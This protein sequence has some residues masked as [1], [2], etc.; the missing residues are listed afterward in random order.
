MA[1]G[2]LLLLTNEE[3]VEAELAARSASEIELTSILALGNT[4][5][6]W[7]TRAVSVQ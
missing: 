6:R 3:M 1:R 5:I 2:Y 4:D 7:R